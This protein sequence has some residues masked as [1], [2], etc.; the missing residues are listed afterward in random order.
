MKALIAEVKSTGSPV[1]IIERVDWTTAFAQTLPEYRKGIGVKTPA[2]LKDFYRSM[3]ENPNAVMKEK[4]ASKMDSLPPAKQ[5]AL[6]VLMMRVEAS[7]KEHKQSE[8]DKLRRSKINV[9]GSKID[10]DKATVEFE[11][12]L[13]G[14]TKTQTVQLIKVDNQWRFPT[15][16]WDK[17]LEK[18]AVPAVQQQTK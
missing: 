7:M 16:Q 15:L 3:F 11:S 10:G 1:A 8:M 12:L 2:E 17:A 4:L 18:I 13:D 6:E 9:I 14:K 5:A